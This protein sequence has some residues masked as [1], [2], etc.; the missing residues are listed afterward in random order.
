MSFLS[1]PPDIIT[2][3]YLVNLPVAELLSI[4]Q[5]NESITTLCQQ[6]DIWIARIKKEFPEVDVTNI[7]NHRSWYLRQVLFGG[8]IYTHNIYINHHNQATTQQI[9]FGIIVYDDL[10]QR[11]QDIAEQFK[12][13]DRNYLIIYSRPKDSKELSLEPI[14]YQTANSVTLAEGP[15]QKILLVDI[16]YTFRGE[17]FNSYIQSLDNNNK[18]LSEVNQLYN[19][20]ILFYIQDTLDRLKSSLESIVQ[21]HKN[22]KTAFYKQ[23][24]KLKLH[25]NPIPN[26]SSFKVTN[27]EQSRNKIFNY[28]RDQKWD[29]FYYYDDHIKNILTFSS[30]NELI[31]F[32][33]DY[34]NTLTAEQLHTLEL[35]IDGIFPMTKHYLLVEKNRRKEVSKQEVIIFFNGDGDLI[36]FSLND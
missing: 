24:T 13:P 19:V 32:Q 31:E 1:Q 2:Y 4:C 34:I 17:T 29:H 9:P 27:I 33:R 35:L 18:A 26:A 22:T 25:R 11:V 12:P 5:V 28:I 7:E 8:K 14:A 36:Y 23:E 3:E 30:L 20:P 10:F 21:F 6:R 16:I 15:H